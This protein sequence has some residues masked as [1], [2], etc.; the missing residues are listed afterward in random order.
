MTIINDI[1]SKIQLRDS[2]HLFPFPVKNFSSIFGYEK[3]FF[4]YF[5]KT[6]NEVL[7]NFILYIDQI[8]NLT[9]IQS[10][11]ISNFSLRL[12]RNKFYDFKSTPIQHLKGLEDQFIRK[13]FIGG[14][15]EA[16]KPIM[17]THFKPYYHLDVNSLYTAVQKKKLLVSYWPWKVV[18]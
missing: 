6:L 15:A 3:M 16:F 18:L 1:G 9:I 14:Y 17:L 13:S 5:S 8:F 7:Q 11:T 12:F 2:F 4:V 10:L